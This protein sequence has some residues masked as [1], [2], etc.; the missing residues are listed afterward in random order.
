MVEE[1]GRD[2]AAFAQMVKESLRRAEQRAVGLRKTNTQLLVA[3]IVSS[4]ATVLVAGGTAAAGP[5]VGQGIPGWRMACV[6]AAILAALSTVCT[7]LTQQ[8]KIGDRLS[9]GN[10]CVGR[11]KSLDVA[12]VT[13]GHAWEEIT[14]E[15]AEIARIYPEFI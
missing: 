12:I 2:R 10:L 13:G 14:K 6:V 8:L 11:L 3:S 15:Y 4:A 5:V 9:Q 1:P 7:G